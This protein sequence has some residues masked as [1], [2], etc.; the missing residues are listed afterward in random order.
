[1]NGLSVFIR[2]REIITLSLPCKDTAR[3]HQSTKQEVGSH[4]TEP[5]S[6]GTL[7]LDFPVSRNCEK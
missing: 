1:M 2:D 7:I 6:A 3:R 4:S 5:S